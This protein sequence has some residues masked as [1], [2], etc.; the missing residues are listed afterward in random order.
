[1]RTDSVKAKERFR[2]LRISLHFIAP[3]KVGPAILSFLS[4]PLISAGDIFYSTDT[5]QRMQGRGAH[6]TMVVPKHMCRAPTY[7]NYPPDTQGRMGVGGRLGSQSTVNTWSAQ[8]ERLCHIFRYI[9][10]YT[11]LPL[12][13]CSAIAITK[14]KCPKNLINF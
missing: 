3:V 13:V 14:H 10:C 11:L 12:K 6:I 9:L 8:T 4:S 1:M 2:N 7:K 5:E